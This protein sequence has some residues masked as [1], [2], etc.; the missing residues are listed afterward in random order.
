MRH[1]PTVAGILLGLLFVQAGLVV[2]LGLVPTP[3]PPPEGTPLAQFLG[4]FGPTGYLTFVKVLEVTGGVLVALPHTRNL[5]LLVLVPILVNIVAFHVLVVG[6][7]SG[8]LEPMLDAILVLVAYLLWVE[9][10]AFAGLVSRPLP[11]QP[12]GM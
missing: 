10:R 1:V 2:L 11:G 8:L 12:T 9:R 3:P 7:S 5:G 6:S 4:A